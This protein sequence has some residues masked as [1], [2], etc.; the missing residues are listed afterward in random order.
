MTKSCYSVESN[1]LTSKKLVIQLSVPLLPFLA[2]L[3]S[4]R[5]SR[6]KTYHF[7][8]CWGI[9]AYLSKSVETTIIVNIFTWM[10]LLLTP[11]KGAHYRTQTQKLPASKPS[12]LCK[13]RWRYWLTA[14]SFYSMISMKL[15][16]RSGL[17]FL[18]QLQIKINLT[19]VLYV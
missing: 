17:H 15:L 14:E 9:L 10:I 1:R 5:N 8:Y 3:S 19:V 4:T 12:L 2:K 7:R 11:H 13:A 18:L 16:R 6:P